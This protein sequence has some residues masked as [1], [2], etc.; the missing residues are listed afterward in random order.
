MTSI[1]FERFNGNC[2]RN[3]N[4]DYALPLQR[5]VLRRFDLCAM[6]GRAVSV[7]AT[8]TVGMKSQRLS[9]SMETD[10]TAEGEINASI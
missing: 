8:A 6:V 3:I 5:R 2:R 4:E 7:G 1:S 9:A 10:R